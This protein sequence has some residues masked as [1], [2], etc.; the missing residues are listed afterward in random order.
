MLRAERP[1]IFSSVRKG[2][3]PCFGGA[4]EVDHPENGSWRCS[5]RGE[6]NCERRRRGVVVGSP[7]IAAP[8]DLPICMLPRRFQNRNLIIFPAGWKP[9]PWY[10]GRGVL[11]FT[12]VASYGLI[13]FRNNAHERF[14]NPRGTRAIRTC[15]PRWLYKI[16]FEIFSGSLYPWNLFERQMSLFFLR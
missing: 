8:F 7:R 1:G 11:D 12:L 9:V 6:R 10:P 15:S 14:T 4:V 5:R 16:V 13:V 2:G 3:W